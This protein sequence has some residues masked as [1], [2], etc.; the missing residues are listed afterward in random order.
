MG[1][2]LPAK[3]GADARCAGLGTSHRPGFS[4]VAALENYLVS[5]PGTTLQWDPGC[6]RMGEE[7]L[8]SAPAEM[9]AF[10]RFCSEHKIHFVLV[11]SG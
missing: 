2:G 6:K 8:L 11:P 7:P 5:Q 1:P 4:T 9:E 10:K 3:D